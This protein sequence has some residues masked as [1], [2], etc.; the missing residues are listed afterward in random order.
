[1]ENI[2]QVYEGTLHISANYVCFHADVEGHSFSVVIPFREVLDIIS[3]DS[4]LIQVNTQSNKVRSVLASSCVCVCVCVCDA[5]DSR[6]PLL[7]FSVW[8]DATSFP[9]RCC[10]DGSTA[11]S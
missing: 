10:G 2:I 6:T 4:K 5:E 3:V 8:P 7:R 11:A 9:F 1:M